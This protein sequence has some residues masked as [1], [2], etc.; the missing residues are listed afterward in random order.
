MIHLVRCVLSITPLR[1]INKPL[2]TTGN[3]QKRKHT[4][5]SE[6]DSNSQTLAE[7]LKNTYL[8]I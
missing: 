8:K 1:S 5:W 6:R 4:P 3:A 2:K 7:A